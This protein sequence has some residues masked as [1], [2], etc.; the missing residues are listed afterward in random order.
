MTLLAEVLYK[1]IGKYIKR[2]D[3]YICPNGTLELL[4]KEWRIRKNN[5]IP[6]ML[7]LSNLLISKGVWTLLDACYILKEKGYTFVLSFC[8]WRNSRNILLYN[9][10]MR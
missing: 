6:H 7:F 2:K 9:L 10:L 8:R 4:K 3:V 5:K 1:D